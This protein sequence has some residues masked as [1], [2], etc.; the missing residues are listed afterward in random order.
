MEAIA[1]PEGGWTSAKTLAN[2]SLWIH[3][4]GMRKGLKVAVAVLVVLLVAFAGWWLTRAHEPEYQGRSLSAWLDEYNKAG[5]WNVEPAN[6]AIRA[7]GT[8]CL[9]FLLAHIKHKPSRL[10]AKVV[11]LVSKQ[12]LLKLPFYGAER[13]GSA[14]IVALNAL[15][16][17]ASPLCPELL[18]L[19]KDS[20]KW[21][22]AN[23]SLL[24]IG[25]NAIPYL[26]AACENAKPAGTDAVL[27]MAM[28]KRA[29][30]PHFS[31]GQF[32]APLNGKPIL[33]LGYAVSA[34]DV[35]EIAKTLQHPSPAVRRASAEALGLHT[36][37]T[38]T[39]VLKSAVPLLVN[40]CSDTNEAVRASA[41]ATLKLIDPEAAAKAGI[42]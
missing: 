23:L 21:W 16:P 32:K 20:G 31:W 36:G 35:G 5:T 25:T 7:M 18:A 17:E 27:M 33:I 22:F 39:E 34:E 37:S 15:G 24:A 42:K 29:P 8:N 11:G 13:Y 19:T 26:E 9:P 14:S 12:R 3:A 41:G 2:G 30:P 1:A 4:V 28:M 6:A 40:A 38:Y 10:K